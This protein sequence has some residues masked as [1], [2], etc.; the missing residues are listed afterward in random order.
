[1]ENSLKLR[2]MSSKLPTFLMQWH[3]LLVKLPPLPANVFHANATF[4]DELAASTAACGAATGLSL[5]R[6]ALLGSPRVNKRLAMFNQRAG[7]TLPTVTKP[8]G[9][10]LALGWKKGKNSLVEEVCLDYPGPQIPTI[11]CSD[12]LIR[13]G[14]CGNLRVKGWNWVYCLVNPQQPLLDRFQ[15]NFFLCRCCNNSLFGQVSAHV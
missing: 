8:S 1:M 3:G 9:Q 11:S 6:M 2:R 12:P 13:A 10:A 4:L 15:N 14:G 5:S 7:L